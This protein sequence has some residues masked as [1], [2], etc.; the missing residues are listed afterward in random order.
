[1]DAPKICAYQKF[2]YPPDAVSA[3]EE[4]AQKASKVSG[5]VCRQHCI[6]RCRRL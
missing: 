6:P 3:L 1:M 4:R 5:A 2:S